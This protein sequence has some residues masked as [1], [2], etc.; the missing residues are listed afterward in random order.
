MAFDQEDDDDGVISRWS[1][2]KRGIAIA[3][4]QQEEQLSIEE[5][6]EIDDAYQAELLQNK[7]AAEEIDLDTIDEESDLSIFMKAGVPEALKKQALSILWRSNPVFANVDGLNDY[8]EDFGSSDLILK[9]FKS[10][11]QAGKGYLQKEP[12]PE[13]GILADGE[14]ETEDEIAEVIDEDEIDDA[15]VV[16]GDEQIDEQAQTTEEGLALAQDNASVE[17]IEEVTEVAQPKVSLR[18]R[19][20]QEG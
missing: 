13:E 10:A 15:D 5:Q 17:I 11:Y 3:A 16:D 1:K 12:D 8:D 2:R 14:N 19:L 7:Q 18:Q 4:E 20:M 6:Q 9:T